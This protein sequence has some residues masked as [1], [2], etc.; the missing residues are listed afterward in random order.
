M[1]SGERGTSP[2]ALTIIKYYCLS[3]TS[4]PAISCPQVFY[5]TGAL[6]F[7]PCPHDKILEQTK[8]KAF[9][10]EKLNVTIK[11]I[12]V[13]DKV[14]NIVG[15][16]EIACTSNFSFFHSFKN[17]SFLDASK[18]VIVWEWVNLQSRL[19]DPV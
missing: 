1:D 9:A 3:P 16:G 18:G 2:V 4:K 8:L 13:F 12:S 6:P 10:D 11:I 15:K 19:N 7:N 14:E 5:T 17:A